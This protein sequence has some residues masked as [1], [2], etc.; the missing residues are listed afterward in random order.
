MSL[1]PQWGN[2]IS[3]DELPLSVVT[4]GSGG[5]PV[6]WTPN[7]LIPQ[8]TI[9]SNAGSLYLCDITHT[10]AATFAADASNFTALGGAGELL[11][12]TFYAPTTAV[13]YAITASSLT[14][15][16]TTNLSVGFTTNAS[17][18]GSTEV[19]ARLTFG[20]NIGTILAVGFIGTG[21][22]TES[23]N[24]GNNA[25][26]QEQSVEIL[27]AG[28]TPNTAYSWDFAA[29]VNTGTNTIYAGS[30]ASG[31]GGSNYPVLMTVHAGLD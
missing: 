20:A 2:R 5:G 25:G 7:T 3:V 19:I 26:S 8:N 15:V 24:V 17:G 9:V 30:N 16:D 4:G 28:L 1:D 13:S 12:R 22:P 29:T 6:A 21:A 11:G 23:Y 10:S 27:V 14:A 31:V 18:P